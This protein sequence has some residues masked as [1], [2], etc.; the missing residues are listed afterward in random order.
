[1]TG[2]LFY[3]Y[4]S[5]ITIG[6]M[7]ARQRVQQLER[8]KLRIRRI[9]HDLK[10]PLAL[11]LHVT[12][13]HVANANLIDA[14]TKQFASRVQSINQSTDD[15]KNYKA[16]CLHE[17]LDTAIM[18]F[19][20]IFDV[21]GI[22]LGHES[23]IPNTA[24]ILGLPDD[25]LRCIENLLSNASKFTSDN[26]CVTVSSSM[27]VEGE[28]KV[29]VSLEVR[30]TGKGLRGMDFEKLFEDEM[31][32]QKDAFGLGLGLPSVKAF[33][34]SEGGH[35]WCGT[36]HTENKG[37]VFG[38]SFLAAITEAPDVTSLPAE[39]RST[40]VRGD[41]CI[42]VVDDD[43]LQLRVNVMK[44]KKLFPDAY[45][46]TAK[47][48]LSG[49]EQMQ[50]HKYDAVFSDLNMP[51]LNGAEMY[52]RARD[53]G[54]LPRVFKLLSAQTFENTDFTTEY[55]L[56]ANQL[57]DKV[58]TT[59][60]AFDDAVVELGDEQA[61]E[62]HTA[63]RDDEHTDSVMEPSLWEAN[64]LCDNLLESLPPDLIL[65]EFR[66]SLRN[67]EACT[68]DAERLRVIH[69][70]NGAAAVVGARAV[71]AA[72]ET[73]RPGGQVEVAL[74]ASA[75]EGVK[76]ALVDFC[77]ELATGRSSGA[78]RQANSRAHSTARRT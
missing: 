50:S 53:C 37:A 18:G 31:K 8:E 36:N 40:A 49:L 2:V 19:K 34:E 9:V 12:K 61:T 51:V 64:V 47:D 24:H 29:L 58:D 11:L 78:P 38:F 25:I 39:F 46:D 35:V 60:N 75:A 42:L 41:M 10:Q 55:G 23:G 3:V 27:Q 14:L 67:F 15:V 1:M 66:E 44:V 70:V 7:L 74:T 72:C 56:A 30:D 20:G 68:S 76:Q 13:D 4:S 62:P 16:L 65:S 54:A 63:L 6:L 33:A 73:A 71:E 26:G 21:R 17:F 22:V 32:G 5:I 48:G 45:V 57:Y 52:M 43:G 28:E 69:K 77:D 59:K